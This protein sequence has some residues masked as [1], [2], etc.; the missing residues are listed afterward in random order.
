MSQAL[1]LKEHLDEAGHSVES[2]LLGIRAPEAV[3]D[4][5]REAFPGKLQ[6]FR[7][8]WFLR[9]P[10]KK[11]I[12]V[13]RT[14]G[15]NLLRSGSYMKSIAW[16][17]REIEAIRPDV[18]F[19]FY[20]LLG[21]WAMRKV[22]PGIR[23]IGL[24]HH[25]YLYLNR[26]YCSRGP[27]WQRGLLHLHTRMI[28]ESCQQVLALSFREEPGSGPIRV[29][30]PLVRR[31]FRG[32]RHVPG[33]RYLV[34][35]LQEGFLYDLVQLARQEPGFQADVFTSLQPAMDLPDGIRIHPFD[36]EKFCKF[37]A[38]CKGLITTAGFDIIAEAACHG[39]PLAVVPSRNH[40]EQ[41][42]NAAE[43][44]AREMGISAEQ[45]D[46]GILKQMKASDPAEYKKWLDQAGTRI[47]HSMKG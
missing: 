10:N 30:P 22:A 2:V 47:I 25:F 18:I 20:E 44:A 3:P 35:F 41:L 42:C 39:I 38:S 6:I 13:G 24:G 31:E 17:R 19:N 37:M 34:Y 45:I 33:E 28:M 4:Y 5:F 14:L 11:G 26:R 21:A 12:Y 1:A 32:I 23:T 46:R 27:A 15:Y 29:V 43:I 16:I 7:S 40:L 9:T 8:P 36:A